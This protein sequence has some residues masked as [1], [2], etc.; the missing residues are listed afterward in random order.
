MTSLRVASDHVRRS[1][2]R[3]LWL[4]P[5]CTRENPQPKIGWHLERRDDEASPERPWVVAVVVSGSNADRAGIRVGDRLVDVGGAP[6]TLDRTT[7]DAATSGRTGRRSR[8]RFSAARRS[9]SS[10][11]SR[12]DCAHRRNLSPLACGRRWAVTR[13]LFQADF[14]S[15]RSLETLQSSDSA[16]LIA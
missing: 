16:T 15:T 3:R 13:R 11:C 1:L 12:S 9:S 7:I 2:A 4:N 6:A 5:P 10:S 8:S 14:I